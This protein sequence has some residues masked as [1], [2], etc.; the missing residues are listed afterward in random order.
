MSLL[1]LAR[2][3]YPGLI[4][5]LW[6]AGGLLIYVISLSHRLMEAAGPSGQGKEQELPSE[7]FKYVPGR[8]GRKRERKDSVAD[9]REMAGY[10]SG[11]SDSSEIVFHSNIEKQ[12]LGLHRVTPIR[13]VAFT[14]SVVSWGKSELKVLLSPAA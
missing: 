6:L 12:R 14:M 5:A 2:I 4:I 11:A 3:T 9:H 8:R 1:I 10:D 13:S 7:P